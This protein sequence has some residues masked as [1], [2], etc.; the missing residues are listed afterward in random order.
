MTKEYKRPASLG[1]PMVKRNYFIPRE[2]AEWITEEA[3]RRGIY[4]AQLIRDLIA[5]EMER[6]NGKPSRS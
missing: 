1:E 6:G 4:E 5:A 2:Y 3:A